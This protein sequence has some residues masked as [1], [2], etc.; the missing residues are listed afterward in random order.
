MRLILTP[1]DVA[2]LTPPIEEAAASTGFNAADYHRANGTA[3]GSSGATLTVSKPAGTV[4]GDLLVVCIITP[5]NETI[6]SVPSGWT[7]ITEEQVGANGWNRAYWKIAA[8]EGASWQWTKS[9]TGGYVHMCVAYKDSAAATV[10]VSASAEQT[11]ANTTVTAP[12]VVATQAND[13]LIV[14][15]MSSGARSHTESSGL[16]AE[17]LDAGNPTLV[18]YDQVV[19][20]SGATGTRTLTI[21]AATSTWAVLTIAFK[22]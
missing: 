7:L 16:M 22:K 6:S 4:D 15:N 1:Y 12:S 5:A 18:W 20:A 3:V 13:L 19:A 17:R 11:V 21:S 14:V 2:L 10:D 8:S 9:S